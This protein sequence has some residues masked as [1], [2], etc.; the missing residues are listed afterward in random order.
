MVI[1]REL[2]ESECLQ[3]LCGHTVGRIAM[4]TPQGPRVFPVNYVVDDGSL[5]IRTSPYG[6]IA[7]EGGRNA[8]MAFEVDHLDDES[9]TGWSVLVVGRA[10]IVD[11]PHELL[12]LA[13]NPQPWAGGS[14]GLYL[15]LRWRLISGRSLGPVATTPAAG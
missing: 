11:D 2:T 14:R 7:S 5:V 9:R 10:E 3:A 8:E 15:R 4:C 12:S 1:P 6:T 13:R